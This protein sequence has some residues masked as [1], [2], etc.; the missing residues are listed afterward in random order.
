MSMSRDECLHDCTCCAQS[1]VRVDYAPEAVACDLPEGHADGD[2]H[3]D[4]R[5]GWW[6][7]DPAA[8]PRSL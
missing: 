7:D 5:H 4:P 3:W 2:R 1:L 8:G 6:T